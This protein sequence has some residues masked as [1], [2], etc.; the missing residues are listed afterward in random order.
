MAHGWRL[1]CLA[2][3]CVLHCASPAADTNVSDAQASPWAV[4]IGVRA[5]RGEQWVLA[6]PC[7]ILSLKVPA[8]AGA[9]AAD[10]QADLSLRGCDASAEG[11]Q[12]G[13]CPQMTVTVLLDQQ[14]AAEVATCSL[15]CSLR[16]KAVG[17]GEHLVTATATGAWAGLAVRPCRFVLSGLSEP[18]GDGEATVYS[19]GAPQGTTASEMDVASADG[20]DR[21]SA[22]EPPTV[23]QDGQ[24]V[25]ILFPAD[26]TCLSDG[27]NAYVSVAVTDGFFAL[28]NTHDVLARF[29]TT[30]HCIVDD[31]GTVL[32]APIDYNP[33]TQSAL[34][35]CHSYESDFAL[36]D[37]YVKKMD[38]SFAGLPGMGQHDCGPGEI[39]KHDLEDGFMIDIWLIVPE[40][41]QTLQ[42]D[43]AAGMHISRFFLIDARTR[44]QMGRE[45]TGGTYIYPFQTRT[46]SHRR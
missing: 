29:E 36:R 6:L 8:P 10:L 21:K 41:G 44:Q 7:G 22:L 26:D 28:P 5:A 43:L 39:C 9:W 20:A 17:A 12:H 31:H 2:L 15:P 18:A 14:Y 11:S 35:Q 45:A 4:A 40:A 23:D 27:H 19:I 46:H 37:G 13:A 3:A 34:V 32:P 38:G 1:A 42:S 24:Y 33:K 30:V 25:A 16:L